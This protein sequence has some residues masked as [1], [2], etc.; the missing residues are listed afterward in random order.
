MGGGGQQ[1]KDRFKIYICCRKK[2]QIYF[3]IKVCIIHWGKGGGTAKKG[4]FC[5]RKSIKS[6]LEWK[7]AFI[8]IE[9]L[10]GDISVEEKISTVK[11]KKNQKFALSTG[12]TIREKGDISAAEN[13]EIWNVL[14]CLLLYPIGNKKDKTSKF[15]KYISEY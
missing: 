10:G 1:R 13:Y 5:C 7:F 3:W 11:I 6:F 15:V 9:K 12:V 2:Y 14:K 8:S 4:Y